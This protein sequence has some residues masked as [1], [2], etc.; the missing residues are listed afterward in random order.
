MNLKNIRELVQLLENSGL[1][2]LEVSEAD[3]KIRLEKN[4]D[5]ILSKIQ[6]LVQEAQCL[7]VLGFGFD[8]NNC[9]RIGFEPGNFQLK[10]GLPRRSIMFTNFGDINRTNKAASRAFF[11]EANAFLSET[12]LH[13]NFARHYYEK[14]VRDCYGALA[15][16]FDELEEY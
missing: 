8:R 14:S 6:S 7:Y 15:Y 9:A 3:T 16:D 2:V 10:N 4:D 12:T 1:S 13:Q 11:G 5:E